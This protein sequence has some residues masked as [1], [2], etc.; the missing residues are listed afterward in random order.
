MLQQPF[1]VLMSLYFKET[2][3]NLESCFLSLEQQTLQPK[4]IILVIDGPIDNVLEEVVTRWES[5]LSVQR[6]QLEKNIGLGLALAEGMKHCSCEYIAR[7]DTDDI[8]FP[9]RFQRQMKFME[10][11]S[12]VA[13][14]GAAVIEFDE[15]GQQRLKRLPE[16]HTDIKRFSRLK[17]PFNHMSVI[18]KKSV[19]EQVGGY[20]HHLFM[21]DYNLWLRIIAENFTTHNLTDILL[22][23]RVGSGMLKKRRGFN[24][25]KSEASLFNLKRQLKTVSIVNN[26]A[27]FLVRVS[28]RVAPEKFLNFLY[29]VDRVKI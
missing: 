10:E 2:P 25:I 15:T 17:N 11:N 24:Y 23:V 26:L 9:E 27:A 3:E 21:E 12:D 7:M 20:R 8:C 1:S 19:V 28:T 16:N 14:L 18:F 13:L 22:N 29:R 5:K 4:E 6:V